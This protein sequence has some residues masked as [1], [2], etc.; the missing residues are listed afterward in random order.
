MRR[1][2]SVVVVAVLGTVLAT[3]GTT[4]AASAPAPPVAASSGVHREAVAPQ[5]TVGSNAWVAVAVARL[6]LSPGSP[7]E[8]DRPALARPVRF[9]EWLDTMTLDQ[10]RGLYY[11]SPTEA[12]LGDRVVVVDLRPHWARVVVPSQPSQKDPRGYPGWVPRRQ[13]TAQRPPHTDQEAT[14]VRRTAW[15]RTD[16]G[17]ATHVI[18]VS[19]GTRLHVLSRVGRYVRVVTPLGNYRR[20]RQG[21]VVVHPWGTPALSASRADLVAR[22]RSFLGLSYLWGGLSGFGVDCSGLT[23]ID[24]RLHGIRI[25]RDALPQSQHGRHVSSL[26]RADLL[27]YGSPVHH[28]TMYVGDGWMIQAER[29]GTQVKLDRTS[30]QPLASEYVGARRYY[31]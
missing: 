2:L 1:G 30:D 14:V 15:L 5:L 9:R 7:R 26:R 18:E 4:G 25:P 16:D 11:L 10:R 23:W 6:W 8:V 19:V 17:A 20:I 13:L 31:P 29:T 12:L 21:G 28:V 24:Y 22:A 3:V 27:F